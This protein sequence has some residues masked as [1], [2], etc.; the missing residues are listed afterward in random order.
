ME[1]PQPRPD[2]L[3]GR[4][5]D[6]RYQIHDLLAIGGMGS[7][8]RATHLLMRKACAIKVL[9]AT[10]GAADL[11]ARRF[12]REAESASR[13]DHEHCIRVSDFGVTEDG[14]PYLVMELLDG[15]SLAEELETRGALKLPRVLTIARQIALALEHAHGLGIVHRDLKPDNVFLVRRPGQGD[16]VK[17]LD[18]GL[19]KLVEDGAGSAAPSTLSA[20][21]TVF[22]TPEYMSPEQAEA[23]P[24]DARSDLYAFGCLLYQLMT[25]QLPFQ[26]ATHVAILT[27]H[28]SERPTSPAVRRPDLSLPPALVDLCLRCL[29]KKPAQRPPSAGAIARELDQIGATAATE[30]GAIPRVSGKVASLV[31]VE[32]EPPP[33]R[34]SLLPWFLAGAAV[35]ALLFAIGLLYFT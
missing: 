27:K 18:F 29:E 26:A 17:V 15:R 34:R 12:R 6:G 19:A 22:G 1:S 24:I 4:V 28:I 33:P 31:T 5:L 2:P 25:G 8:Y 16:F 23:R 21:G 20:M 10:S 14:L 35:G 30:I 11:A 7:I 32:L 3:L 9:R 13:L